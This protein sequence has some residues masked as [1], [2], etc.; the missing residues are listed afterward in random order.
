MRWDAIGD[1]MISLPFFRKVR[2]A[3]PEAS[4]GILAS[5]R[6][7]PLLR[8]EEGFTIILY[9]SSPMSYLRSLVRVRS[10]R[11]DA[12]V[13]TRMHYDSMTSFLYGLVGGAGFMVSA[14]NRD[15]RLPYNVRVPIPE[16]RMHNAELT[17]LLLEALGRPLDDGDLDRE[18]RLSGQ[19]LHFA[20]K[21]W[22]EAGI[23]LRGR[24]VAVNMAARDPRHHWPHEKVEDL[25]AGLLEAHLS[26]VLI[27]M[28]PQRQAAVSIA[29]KH[30]GVITAPEC[31]TILHA[32]ALVRDMAL[33][34]SPDTGLVHV[35]SSFG[36]PVVGLYTPNEDHLPLWYP[37]RTPSIVLMGDGRVSDI[38]VRDVLNATGELIMKTS[39]GVRI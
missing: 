24:A 20:D 14:C 6:N 34:V 25:C 36:I 1:M 31:P 5:R 30:P 22:R 17:G 37:W 10:F 16:E 35:A 13:D 27:S 15:Q 18:P 9:G 33:L 29:M 32:A 23:T 39:I 12:I 21:F 11:P 38:P 3:F 19:E 7:A 28:S 26:P 8:Y 4:V 2:D